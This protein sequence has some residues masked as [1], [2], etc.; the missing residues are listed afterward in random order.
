MLDTRVIPTLLLK[1]SGLV[2]TTKF[3]K[4]VYIGD[5]I[6]AIKIFNSKEVDELI[7]LDITASA[8]GR[9]PAFDT[10]REI[11]DE[12]F[13]PLSYGGGIRTVEHIRA[14]LK[15]GIEKVVLNTSA[16]TDPSL[17]TKAADEFGRQ[18]IICS[19]DVKKSLF[20]GYSVH[21]ASGAKILEKDPVAYA[22]RLEE[23]GAGEIYLTSVDREGTMSGYDLALVKSVCAAVSVP[24]IASGGAGSM[25]DFVAARDAGAS[26]VSAGA[27]F[28]FQGPHRAVLITYPA[29]EELETRLGGR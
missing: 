19:I 21:S 8:E 29:R 28:V 2:K 4:P 18:A 13:M 20:G 27:M 23:L 10:I 15:A 9:P 6:N 25:D 1:G 16:L 3:A 14:I 24:V 12:C 5:P 11:T 26:A 22:R 17:V 7:I